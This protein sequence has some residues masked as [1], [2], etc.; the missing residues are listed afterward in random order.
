MDYLANFFTGQPT[1]SDPDTT[2]YTIFFGIGYV[3]SI[4][5]RRGLF[6]DQSK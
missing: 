5:V 3:F 4:S 1:R 6:M 2:L